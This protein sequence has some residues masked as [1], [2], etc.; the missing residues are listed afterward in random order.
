MAVVSQEI[1]GKDIHYQGMDRAIDMPSRQIKIVAESLL[2]L[3]ILLVSMPIILIV[4]VLV[5][6]TSRGPV[7]YAQKRL[8]RNGLVFTIYKIRTM[9]RDSEPNGARWCVP[10]DRRVTPVGRLLR[11]T[12]ID[13]LPQLINVLQGKMS[14]IGPRPERP[15]IVLELEKVL[16][17]YRRRLDVRPGLTGLAQV[18]QPPDTDLNMVRSKLAFDLHYVDHWSLWLDLRILLATVPHVLSIPPE[19]IARVFRLPQVSSSSIAELSSPTAVSL[20]TP[21]VLPQMSEACNPA[22]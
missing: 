6:M 10:G 22:G 16:P 11:C 19:M 2:A 20:A 1:M 12:H 13:E 3:L 15:E 5:R 17:R 18:L 4:V 9:Y 8:G 14:L 7:I 21:Q